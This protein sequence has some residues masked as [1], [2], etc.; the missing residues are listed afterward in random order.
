MKSYLTPL[1][2]LTLSFQHCSPLNFCSDEKYNKTSGQDG[3]IGKHGLPTHT[4]TAKVTTKLWNNYHPESSENWAVWKSKELKISHSF[5]WGVGVEV[6]RHG[7]V[8]QTAPHPHL[9][10]KNQEEYLGS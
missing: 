3:G 10:D 9:V 7:E 1:D 4:T 8:E 6:H 2:K 5:R